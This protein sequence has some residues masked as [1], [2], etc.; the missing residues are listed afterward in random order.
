MLHAVR[1]LHREHR[2]GQRIEQHVPRGV[3][4]FL[5]VD[6]VIDHVVG[7]IDHRLVRL[8]TDGGTDVEVAHEGCRHGEADYF[9][10]RRWAGEIRG[11]S[12]RPGLRHDPS[13]GALPDHG[14]RSDGNERSCP[15]SAVW[16]Q[17]VTVRTLSAS[18]NRRPPAPPAIPRDFRRPGSRRP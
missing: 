8:G 12:G 11:R 10:V 1:E 3:V 14:R 9:A 17:I 15:F 18:L 2:A 4:G 6:S 13:S 16:H 5:R 7:D